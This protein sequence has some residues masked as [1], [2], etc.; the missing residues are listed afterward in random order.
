MPSTETNI[1]L[2]PAPGPGIH[3]H[4]QPPHP[5]H[6][7]SLPHC[8]HLLLLLPT[9]PLPAICLRRREDS[10]VFFFFFFSRALK[11]PFTSLVSSCILGEWTS[12]GARAEIR[13]SS[14][15]LSGWRAVWDTLR[16][17]AAVPLA[18]P[19]SLAGLA[20]AHFKS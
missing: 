15:R 6:H 13:A 7:L 14:G 2:Q 4:T 8:L 12:G 1:P 3:L 17:N 16:S 19:A 11:M 5:A 10:A 9:I 20:V 18:S